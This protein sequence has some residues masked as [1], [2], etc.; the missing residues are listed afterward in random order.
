MASAS[1]FSLI[2]ICMSGA[3][4]LE[5]TSDAA[6]SIVLGAYL[7]REWF[8]G[9]WDSSQTDESIAYKEFFPIAIAAHI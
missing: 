6:C 4:A 2:H 8:N 1:G 9:I 5:V 7:E 3:P